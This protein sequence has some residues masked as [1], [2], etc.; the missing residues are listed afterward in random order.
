MRIRLVP[1]TGIQ[2]VSLPSLDESLIRQFMFRMDVEQGEVP[3]GR[4]PKIHAV[5][6]N[7]ESD[8]FYD[9]EEGAFTTVS[10]N[11]GLLLDAAFATGSGFWVP[12]PFDR[13]GAWVSLYLSPAESSD[14][15]NMLNAVLAVDTTLVDDGNPQGIE[16]S[17]LGDRVPRP[18]SRAFWRKSMIAGWV[19]A[20][21]DRF[22]GLGD[23]VQLSKSNPGRAVQTAVAALAAYLAEGDFGGDGAGIAVRFA[24]RPWRKDAV[25]VDVVLDLGNSRTC[26]LLTE[27]TPELKQE[28]LEVVYPSDPTQSESCP[29]AT[30]MTFVEH[31]VIGAS[32]DDP[33][34]FLFLSQI[35]LGTRAADRLRNSRFDPQPLG[36]S[37]PKRYLWET[38]ESVPWNWQLADRRD[39]DGMPPVLRG[40]ALKYMDPMRPMRPPPTP[41]EPMSPNH[42]RQA[43][44]AWAIIE[45]L[46]QAFRQINSVEWRRTEANAP[47]CDR[48]REIGNL[49]IMYPAGMH[50]QEIKN[51]QFAC[52]YA[53]KLWSE[54]RS[55][56]EIFCEGGGV[57]IDHEYG[58]RAP[59]V[60]VIC[61]E[62]LAIQA[63]WLYGEILHRYKGSVADAVKYLGRRR[64]AKP[65]EAS[66]HEGDPG[67]IESDR[68]TLRIASLDIGGGTIDLAIADYAE[69]E[70]RPTAVALT[71]TRRFHDGIS[72]AGDEIMKGLLESAVFPQ[73]ILQTGCDLEKWEE[74]ITRPRS[75]RAKTLGRRLVRGVWQPLAMAC[76]ELGEGDEDVEVSMSDI[77]GKV[78][79][80]LVQELEMALG[81][82]GV[83]G[84]GIS[85]VRIA[86]SRLEMKKIVQKTVGRTLTQ[87]ADIIDQ[88]Q[89][90]LL[91]VGGRPSSNPAIRD[92]IRLAMAVPPGQ[93]VFLS[94]TSVGDWYPFIR[95]G[96]RISDAKTCA[97]VGGAIVFRAMYGHG[98]FLLRSEPTAEPE[99]IIGYLRS[100]HD[101]EA[102]EFG[103]GD[104]L[105]LSGAGTS[106]QITPQIGDNSGLMLAI[107]RIDHPIAEAK[108]IY[109]I[110]LK[111]RFR[112][113]LAE[114]PVHQ[115]SVEVRLAQGDRPVWQAEQEIGKQIDMPGGTINDVVELAA[116]QGDVA[117]PGGRTVDGEDAFELVLKTMID[118]AGYWLDTGRFSPVPRTENADS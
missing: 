105:D 28:R 94:E 46:E 38:Q 82:E 79:M 110:R 4:L 73:I 104:R 118:G 22:H 80:N 78:A 26:A 52:R 5:D 64:R 19:H 2:Y 31:E 87:C 7:S 13:G 17:E 108:P 77:A 89:C 18:L 51:Y 60:Q 21:V 69:D 66:A 33:E 91:I 68:S 8:D 16:S 37:S 107:R 102:V 29:F 45:I 84:V 58:V 10:S 93:V 39:K 36:V 85:D 14:G 23:D 116:V 114:N 34:S 24:D 76:L 32:G 43:C 49:V 71:C 35:Q 42:P 88:F 40:H 100:D 41:D 62:A 101:Q 47:A 15:R 99:P 20:T 113:Q 9:E 6:R 111:K 72:R 67:S 70:R 83:D 61:D 117:L 81:L 1:N 57:E 44:T 112:S 48:R 106:I 95:G 98:N 65:A 12:I 74:I 27:E 96:G 53:C 25:K 75:D 63:C 86:I 11:A 97:V 50:G 54:F 56:P 55:N 115:E 92:H 103:D 109:Q 59:N 30:Q 3:H 90:D